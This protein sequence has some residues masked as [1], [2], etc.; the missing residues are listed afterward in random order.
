MALIKGDVVVTDLS[1]LKLIDNSKSSPYYIY[2]QRQV[3]QVENGIMNMS[4]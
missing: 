3:F 1:N 4:I 2:I